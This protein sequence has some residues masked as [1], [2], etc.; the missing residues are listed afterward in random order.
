[1]SLSIII[2]IYILFSLLLIFPIQKKDSNGISILDS[3]IARAISI[4]FIV[5]HHIVQRVDNNSLLAKPFLYFVFLFVGIFFFLSGYGNSISIKKSYGIPYKWLGK[6]VLNLLFYFLIGLALNIMINTDMYLDKNIL[7]KDLFTLTYTPYTLW[8]FKVLLG[9]YFLTFLLYSLACFINERQIALYIYGEGILLISIIYIS[10]C[11]IKRI[12]SFWWNSV[13]A[14]PLGYLYASKTNKIKLKPFIYAVFLVLFSLM[15]ILSIKIDIL[16][17]FAIICLCVLIASYMENYS[18][19]QCN[20]ALLI[21]RI[22][23]GIYLYHLVML[24]LFKNSMNKWYAPIAIIFGSI[25][26]SCCVDLIYKKYLEYV[27]VNE[28]RNN[29]ILG[30]SNKLWTSASVLCIARISQKTWA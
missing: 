10:F 27:N 20:I 22:S 15:T 30:N 17:P 6:R 14:Y 13:I 25:L 7:L 19:R 16:Q 24:S 29:D 8:Y 4:L 5:I 2:I 23:L 3:N 26:L 9:L 1:M 12:P 28:N 11:I 18:F 21:G